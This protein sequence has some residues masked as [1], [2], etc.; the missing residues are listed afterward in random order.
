METH[1]KSVEELTVRGL[2]ARRRVLAR[3]LGGLEEAL[4]GSLVE[5]GRRCGKAVCR[6]AGGELHG[7]YTYL[8]SPGRRR[9]RYVPAAWVDVVARC[10]ARGSEAEAVLAQISAINTELLARRELR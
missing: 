7:P 6:C 8:S 3:Q 2:L 5:Q 4:T 10:L 1:K 9:L